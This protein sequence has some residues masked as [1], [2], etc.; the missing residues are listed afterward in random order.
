M[1][2]IITCIQSW[3]AAAPNAEREKAINWRLDKAVSLGLM[4]EVG[5]HDIDQTNWFFNARPI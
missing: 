4:G 1:V 2:A 3:R 5:C